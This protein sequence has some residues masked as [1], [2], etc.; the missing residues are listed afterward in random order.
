MEQNLFA[1]VEKLMKENNLTYKWLVG[2]LNEKGLEVSIVS[3]SKWVHG[4]QVS[5][6]AEV[7]H[8]MA[9]KIIDL[10]CES[11]ANKVREL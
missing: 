3:L 11:F 10:Y 2:K 4:T 5:A 6:K 9:I 7:V 1:D 8:D